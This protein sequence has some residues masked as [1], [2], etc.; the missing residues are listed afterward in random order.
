MIRLVLLAFVV[1][2]T[3]PSKA[4]APS[5]HLAMDFAVKI[6]KPLGECQP[7]TDDSVLCRPSATVLMW[8]EAK[9]DGKPHCELAADWTPKQSETK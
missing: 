7:W 3:S 9:R 1:A 4:D 5:S 2:C 6:G 8:C